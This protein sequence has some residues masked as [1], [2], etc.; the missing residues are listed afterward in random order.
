M[1]TL[2]SLAK[3]M[4]LTTLQALTVMPTTLCWRHLKASPA[5]QTSPI[6]GNRS[7]GDS[8]YQSQN[9]LQHS[10]SNPAVPEPDFC[11]NDPCS[12]SH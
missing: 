11:R 4:R 7:Q 8:Y 6:V 12:A 2:S 3:D 1:V 9:D 5:A 10:Q